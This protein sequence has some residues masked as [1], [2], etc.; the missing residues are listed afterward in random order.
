MNQIKTMQNLAPAARA[1]RGRECRRQVSA[2][3]LT[4]HEFVILNVLQGEVRS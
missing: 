1:N 2:V 3:G 4:Q